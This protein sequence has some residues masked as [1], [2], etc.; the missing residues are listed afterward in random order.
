V[1]FETGQIRPDENGVAHTPRGDLRA[2]RVP[3]AESVPWYEL[4]R[5]DRTLKPPEELREIFASAGARPGGRAIAY[6][7]VGISA[8]AL[9]YAL[10]LAGIEPEVYD[11]SWDE[12]GRTDRPIARG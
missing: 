1:W 7:G 2:G 9:A 6:C 12:W 8:A 4:Y 3:W 10:D 11:A 5:K